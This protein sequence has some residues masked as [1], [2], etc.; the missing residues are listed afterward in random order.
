MRRFRTCIIRLGAISCTC[1]AIPLWVMF[2]SVCEVRAFIGCGGVVPWPSHHALQ[3]SWQSGPLMTITLDFYRGAYTGISMGESFVHRLQVVSEEVDRIT[4]L[5]NDTLITAQ[6]LSNGQITM[7][8]DGAAT[9]RFARLA[10]ND[11]ALRE[12]AAAL[13]A[14]PRPMPPTLTPIPTSTP[15]PTNTPLPTSTPTPT[16]PPTPTNTPVPTSTAVPTIPP[17]PT[18][19]AVPTIPPTPTNTPLPTVPPPPTVTPTSRPAVGAPFIFAG[20]RWTIHSVENAGH[21]VEGMRIYTPR[22]GWI[23][24]HLTVEYLGDDPKYDFWRFNPQ[25]R[26]YDAWDSS[27]LGYQLHSDTSNCLIG[28]GVTKRKGEPY[29]CKVAYKVEPVFGRPIKGLYMQL[30]GDFTGLFGREHVYVPIEE[31]R[32]QSD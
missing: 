11:S 14:T 16:V 17:T 32:Y 12:V 29:S 6:V 7:T 27:Y 31:H 22:G 26:L 18:S 8:K 1:L 4:F 21:L 23:V 24:V 25:P 10:W 28:K 13:T 15:I 9:L 20:H 30:D 5:S 2:G 19:T 3:G